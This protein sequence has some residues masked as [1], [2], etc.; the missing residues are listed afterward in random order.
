MPT[1]SELV[2]GAL[3][4]AI[5]LAVAVASYRRSRRLSGHPVWKSIIIGAGAGLF[6]QLWLVVWFVKRGDIADRWRAHRQTKQP[7]LAL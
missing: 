5:I 3:L 2:I 7:A 4:P 6:W 1:T